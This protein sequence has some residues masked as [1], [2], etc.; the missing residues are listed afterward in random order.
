MIAELELEPVRNTDGSELETAL[1]LEPTLA[2]AYALPYGA[3]VGVELRAPIGVAGEAESATLYGGPVVRWA[4]HGF[5][6]AVGVQ[7]QL[8]AFSEK[9]PG[10]RLDLSD[11]ERLE[12]RLL[13]GFML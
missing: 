1:E 6:T 12:V 7:P 11:H 13:A 4:D 2:I 3:S 10:S 8:A 9:S 5:W